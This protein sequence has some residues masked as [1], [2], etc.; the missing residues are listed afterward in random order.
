VRDISKDAVGDDEDDDDEIEFILAFE[1][2]KSA[3]ST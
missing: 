1:E 2:P 3:D